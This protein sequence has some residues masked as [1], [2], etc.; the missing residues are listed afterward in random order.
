MDISIQHFSGKS[1]N[2]CAASIYIS[3]YCVV[4]IGFHHWI[5]L[6][7]SN[8][9]NYNHTSGFDG[10][11]GHLEAIQWTFLFN[12]FLAKVEILVP[13][14]Y[15]YLA[16]LWSVFNIKSLSIIATH[17]NKI[18]KVVLMG[19]T[20]IWKPSYGYFYSSIFWQK[21]KFLCCIYINISRCCGSFSASKFPS[22]FQ[23]KQL[24]S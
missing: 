21:S 10:C 23:H 12:N 1:Q 3:I 14:I 19:L 13:H 8:T 22:S 20:E 4:V 15:Q 6:H 9:H 17:T 11:N 24:Q 5:P 7:H 2:S 18:I 16:L